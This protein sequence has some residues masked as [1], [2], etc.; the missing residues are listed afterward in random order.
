[1][2]LSTE[3]QTALEQ[4]VVPHGYLIEFDFSTGFQRA[5][6][7]NQSFSWNGVDWLGLGL[8]GG[9]SAVEESQEV[10]PKALTFTLNIAQPGVLALAIGDP[11]VYAGR[12]VNLFMVPLD[13][14]YRM[15]GTPEACWSGTMESVSVELDPVEEGADEE[16]Q[17]RIVLRCETA[18]NGLRRRPSTRLNPS[19]WRQK[20]P[21]DPSLD[22]LPDLIAKPQLWLSKRFQQA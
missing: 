3:Q 1:M 7:F 19:Q 8:I 21:G 5:S 11:A 2:T 18:I 16:P 20:H 10:A 9:I 15:I 4:P 6:T 14:Q 13:A 22:Y 17:G 12:A